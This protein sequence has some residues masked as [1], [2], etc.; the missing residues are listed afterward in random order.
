MMSAR[1]ITPFSFHKLRQKKQF[2][3]I[4]ID[5]FRA[6]SSIV[7]LMHSGASKIRITNNG[8]DA[9]LLK[10]NRYP[11]SLL[12]GEAKSIMIEGF[13]Y[14]NTPSVFF[15]KIFK[16]KEI[17]FTSSSGAKSVLSL[18]AQNHILIGSLLNLSSVISEGFKLAQSEDCEI[19]IIPSGSAWDETSYVIEDWITGVL[20]ANTLSAEHGFNDIS[21]G[22]FY[23][24]TQ[25]ILKMG[26]TI[27]C[28]LKNSPNGKVLK[29]LGFEAD[30]DFATRLNLIS[31][32]PKIKEFREMDGISFC[33][34]S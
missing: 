32:V 8:N 11:N 22:D 2:I 21:E 13:E 12:I 10:K 17:I 6:T 19:L 14:G 3:S 25:K 1:V 24:K 9:K 23:A 26:H 27:E 29:K 33:V 31:K 16:D 20:I 7:T 15:E 18:K 4:V 5:T 28:L 30:V 34:I